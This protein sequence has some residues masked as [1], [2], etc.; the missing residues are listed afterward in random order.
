MKTFG[1]IG[2]IGVALML[3]AFACDRDYLGALGEDYGFSAVIEQTIDFSGMVTLTLDNPAGEIVI[4]AW[5]QPQ[6]Q[7]TATKK[8]K[9]QAKLDRISVDVQSAESDVTIHTLSKNGSKILGVVHYALKVPASALLALEQG[10]G[11]VEIAGMQGSIQL[12]VGAGDVR[13][14]RVL[15]PVLSVE[16]GAGKVDLSSLAGQSLSIEVG[17]GD[18]RVDAL[19][20]AAFE[21]ISLDVGAGNVE[22]AGVWAPAFSAE[23]GTGN[24]EI[25]LPLG[26]SAQLKASVG[27]GNISIKGFPDM[28]LNQTGFLSKDA[29]AQ[30]GAGEGSIKLSVGMG[31]I[32]VRPWEAPAVP[33]Q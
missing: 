31:N 4:E 24:L 25:E 17:T 30:L 28:Q 9:T 22:T 21:T 15:A 3:S 6:I 13:M 19:V 32:T 10:A 23:V 5:D 16:L 8:A 33:V 20:N 12:E 26:V 27:M 1:V 29:A 11:V 7:L 14:D 18:V 2:L